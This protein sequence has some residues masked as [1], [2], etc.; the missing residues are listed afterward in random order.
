MSSDGIRTS[1][2]AL[3]PPWLQSK[4]GAAFVYTCAL[5]ADALVDKAKLGVFNRF[6]LLCDATALPLLG[7]DY[8][9]PQGPNEPDAGYRVRLQTSWD[10]YAHAGM[11]RAIM[12]QALGYL[13]PLTPQMRVVKDVVIA[14]V[15]STVWDTY[16]AGADTTQAPTHTVQSSLAW[17]W[18]GVVKRWRAW[19][20]IYSLA[21]SPWSSEGTWG[22]GQLWG[23]GG[24]WGLTATQGDIASLRALLAKWRSMGSWYVPG[25]GVIVS[26]SAA[27]FDPTQGAGPGT[28]NPD[29]HWT[30]FGRDNGSG[31][32]IAARFDNCRYLDG[33]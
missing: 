4:V 9:I 14:S 33:A 20:I 12:R 21:G 2:Y 24:V 13:T 19:W 30:H 11:A 16:A 8:G 28:P 31:Q 3:S 27:N 1:L 17:D 29:G 32:L 6:P 18:D 25:G 15:N 5:H 23:D 10:D 26:L 7:A 22:D